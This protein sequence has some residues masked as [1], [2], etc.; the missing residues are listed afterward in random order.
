VVRDTSSRPDNSAASQRPAGEPAAGEP[1]V[2]QPA[3]SQPQRRAARRRLGGFEVAWAAFWLLNLIAM[4]AFAHWATIPFYLIWISLALLYGYRSWARRPTL[5]LLAAVTVTTGAAELADVA[6]N[7]QA[8]EALSKVPLMA[9][10]FSAMVWH[11]QRKRSADAERAQVSEH[12][13][14]LLGTQRRFLQDASHQ[15]RTPITI[16]LGHAELLAR[17][18]AGRV[19]ERDINVVVG[20]LNR[21][22]SL[23]E[24]L[25][26]IAASENP[27]FLRPEPVPLDQFTMEA[28]RRWRPTARRHWQI[29]QLDHVSVNADRERLGL[30]VVALL[31][32]AVR[33]TQADQVIRLSVV[34]DNRSSRA[35]LI[36][37]DTGPGIPLAE[38]G[39]I[40]DRFATGSG[41]G[42][43][44]GTGLGLTLVLAVTRGHGGEVQVHSA[45]GEGS[46]FELLLPV[47]TRAIEGPAGNDP[48][49]SGPAGSGL[50]VP[51][52]DLIAPAGDRRRG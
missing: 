21:L 11:T 31:E 49:G 35:H 6:R 17:E 18:L 44:R 22:R 43:R 8:D 2:G 24:R 1:A 51:G 50:T 15:L 32:N 5:W 4:V 19:E 12:N 37:E 25:L 20:E 34:R 42:G 13:A 46:R 40:F 10:M 45:P 3:A 41:P 38:L 36:V 33:H 9:A 48:A 26:L 29:G 28:L 30:A 39:N 23:S 52:G 27:D 16:A 7:L 47:L 14:R